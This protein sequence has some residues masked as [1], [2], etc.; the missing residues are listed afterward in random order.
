MSPL[1]WAMPT[2]L[3]SQAKRDRA[4]AMGP[5]V[6]AETPVTSTVNQPRIPNVAWIVGPDCRTLAGSRPWSAVASRTPIPAVDD[7]A[8]ERKK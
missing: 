2:E 6:R 3:W 4:P 1:S 8:C 7:Q 5:S